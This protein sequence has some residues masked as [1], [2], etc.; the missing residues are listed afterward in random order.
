MFNVNNKGPF[1]PTT[2]SGLQ[3]KNKQNSRFYECE[4]ILE[5]NCNVMIGRLYSSSYLLDLGLFFLRILFCLL[6]EF[7]ELFS[8]ELPTQ[9]KDK[10]SM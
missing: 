4:R 10:Q 3:I 1:T 5:F 9:K 2:L 8:C 6:G 7:L